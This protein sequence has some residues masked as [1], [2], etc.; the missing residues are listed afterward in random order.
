M[1]VNRQWVPCV[2]SSSFCFIPVIFKLYGCLDHALKMHM[3][4]V[5]NN[6]IIL[7]L[8]LQ[9]DLV[10]FSGIYTECIVD[11]LYAQL[12]VFYVDSFKTLQMLWT[13]VIDKV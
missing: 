10:R 6:K 8:F 7:S 1:K 3:L 5:Y 9:F 13:D 4:I 12:L 11:T 2:R